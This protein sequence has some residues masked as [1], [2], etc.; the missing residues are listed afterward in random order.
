MTYGYRTDGRTL[1][2]PCGGR[3]VERYNYAS[4]KKPAESREPE[5]ARM[6]AA[7]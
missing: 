3:V 1:S 6:Q 4:Q 7:I 2:Y 5:T